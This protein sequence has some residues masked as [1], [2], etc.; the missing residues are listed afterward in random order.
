MAVQEAEYD[1][2]TGLPPTLTDELPPP[3]LD[4]DEPPEPG[5]LPPD[6][7]DAPAP[8]DR[9]LQA[10]APGPTLVSHLEDLDPA[11]ADEYEL[12]EMIAA[13]QRVAAWSHSHMAHLAAILSRRPAVNPRSPLPGDGS[14]LDVTAEEISPRLGISRF[15]ARRL[16]DAGNA[17]RL[18]LEDTAAAL[19]EGLIDYPKACVILRLLGD[20][21]DDVAW[22]VQEVVLPNAPHQTVTQLERDIAKAII[23]VDP[24]RATA[25]ARKARASRRVDHP[26]PLPDGM[27]SMFAVLPA[28]DA[29]GLDL[30]LEAAARTAK[31]SGDTRTLDQLRADALALLGHGALEQGFVGVPEHAGAQGARSTQEDGSTGDGSTRRSSAP[32]PEGQSEGTTEARDVDGPSDVAADRRTDTADNGLGAPSIDSMDR[33]GGPSTDPVDT[34]TTHEYHTETAGRSDTS[35]AAGADTA[36]TRGSGDTAPIGHSPD[37]GADPTSRGPA[38]GAETEPPPG[39]SAADQVPT[40]HTGNSFLRTPHMP[41]DTVGGRRARIHVTVPLSVLIPPELLRHPDDPCSSTSGD[42]SARLRPPDG[43]APAAADLSDLPEGWYPGPTPAEVAELD[44]YGP[45]TPDVAQALAFS[46]ETWRR[47]VTDPLSGQL[48]DVGRTRYRPPAAI[49]EF[50]RMRDRS[51]VSP[52]CSTP[53]RSC[54]LDHIEAWQDGG[55]TSA[56]NVA[57]ECARDHR[58]K[59]TGAF[60]LEHLGAGTFVW[61]TPSGHRYRRD[62]TGRITQLDRQGADFADH[63]P[64]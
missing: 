12:V 8:A 64:F 40:F 1:W 24:H 52:T 9:C 48:L 41:I 51:C 33:P 38:P 39:S 18:K 5:P 11:G 36:T 31:A 44:G 21:P 13:Y 35:T 62:H 34:A 26:R 6:P 50:V 17:F 14:T 30:A 15:A 22:E 19:H 61:T 46:G 55:V 7:L 57:T 58:V 54:Q 32:S 25:R 43:A 59:T 10:M 42:S 23:A 45:I 27:A 53:A 37:D 4:W 16:V 3:W 47:L 60:Q 29:A 20:L 56:E 28:T 49:A 63:P 2:L